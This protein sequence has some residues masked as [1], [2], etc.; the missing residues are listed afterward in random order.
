M[1]QRIQQQTRPAAPQIGMVSSSQCLVN[2]K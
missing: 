2:E 1:L